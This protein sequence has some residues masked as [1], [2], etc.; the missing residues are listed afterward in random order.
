MKY[1]MLPPGIDP[2][3]QRIAP[4][5]TNWIAIIMIGLMLVAMGVACVLISLPRDEEVVLSN[6][7]TVQGSHIPT[8]IVTVVPSQTPE[9]IKTITPTSE[10]SQTP[11]V[12]SFE[13]VITQQI[14]ITKI[15]S[16]DK[17][18]KVEIPIYLTQIVTQI[19]PVTRLSPVTVIV[20][21][22]Q[23]I[24]IPVTATATHTPSLTPT[25][26]NTPTQTSSPTP[27][28]TETPTMEIE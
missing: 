10:P 26:T 5:R 15:I 7:A 24:Y 4:P 3:A 27:T 23:I 9:L 11:V 17:F 16:N 21:I 2:T 22:T 8:P 28:E 6:T 18:T 19:I 13:R 1:Q 20:P 25:I 14:V 12:I